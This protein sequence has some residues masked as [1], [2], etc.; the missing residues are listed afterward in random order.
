MDNDIGTRRNNP[1]VVGT[2]KRWIIGQL[3]PR[4]ISYTIIHNTTHY[5]IKRNITYIHTVLCMCHVYALCLCAQCTRKRLAYTFPGGEILYHCVQIVY[6]ILYITARY[7]SRKFQR[8]YYNKLLYIIIIIILCTL[9]HNDDVPVI[10]L[11]TEWFAPSM[12]NSIF[13]NM[14]LFKFWLLEF[15]DID[16]GRYQLLIKDRHVFKFLRFLYRLK[17]NL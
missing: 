17:N 10:F 4:G 11:Y 13:N 14:N 2:L 1:L 7:R 15:L 16:I 6:G 5:H 12:L 9:T 3:I 8:Q